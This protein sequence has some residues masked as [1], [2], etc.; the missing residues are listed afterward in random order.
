MSARSATS[1]ATTLLRDVVLLG[2]TWGASVVLQRLAVAEIPPLTMVT[3]RLLAALLFFVPFGAKVWRWL[4]TQRQLLPDLLLLGALNPTLSALFSALALQYASSGLVAI[5]ASLAP[6]LAALIGQVLPGKEQ[7]GR[8][9][10]AGLIAAFSGVAMLLGTGHVGLGETWQG[11]IRGH[12]LALAVALVLALASVYTDWRLA[13]R[14]PLPL[15]AGQMLGGLIVLAPFNLLLHTPFDPATI[16]TQAWLAVLLS[17]GIGLGASFILLAK[18]IHR[19]GPTG[20]LLAV[21]VT[22]VAAGG[23]GILLLGETV[24]L[25]LVVG[26]GLVLAGIFLFTRR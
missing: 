25:P 1:S 21:N 7:L 23:L 6:L 12:L 24:T 5:L 19:H 15:A 18:M 17:G 16:S 11:D 3:L 26:A 4:R 8:R 22:P 20:A 10:V 9:Q 14:E 13:G 2:L